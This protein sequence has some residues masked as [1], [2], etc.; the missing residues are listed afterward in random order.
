MEQNKPTK[1]DSHRKDEYMGQY[2]QPQDSMSEAEKF[3][4]N[5]NPV[6]NDQMPAKGLRQV[7]G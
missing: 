2:K 4:T 7:G 6:K 3:G 1:E 5:E